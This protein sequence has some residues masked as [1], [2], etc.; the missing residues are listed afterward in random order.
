MI[1]DWITFGGLLHM[2]MLAIVVLILLAIA[3]DDASDDGPTGWAI[4]LAG[5]FG[6]TTILFTDMPPVSAGSVLAFAAGWLAA[7]SA[8]AT[9][10]WYMLLRRLRTFAGNFEGDAATFDNRLRYDFGFRSWPPRPGDK[11]AEI[12]FWVLFWPIDAAA[13]L[14]GQPLRRLFELLASLFTKMSDSMFAGI[15]RPEEK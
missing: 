5:L 7:G 3:P 12:W 10:R 1:A 2:T 9:L 4:F 8:W 11:A 6:V 15:S 13:R 14:V